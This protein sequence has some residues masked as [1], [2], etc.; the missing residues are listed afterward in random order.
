MNTNKKEKNLK[1]SAETAAPTRR[2][3]DCIRAGMELQ[4]DGVHSDVLGSYTG[5]SEITE[6][7]I[8]DADDL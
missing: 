5:V 7:P 2:A 4:Q 8:Q 3:C 1:K 6:R